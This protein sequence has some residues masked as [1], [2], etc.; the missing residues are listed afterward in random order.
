MVWYH[1][2]IWIFLHH[3]PCFFPPSKRC[4]QNESARPN[5]QYWSERP[6]IWREHSIRLPPIFIFRWH[7]TSFLFHASKACQFWDIFKYVESYFMILLP[8]KHL[9]PKCV[10]N[11]D[12]IFR[13]MNV[14]DRHQVIERCWW[15]GPGSGR[16]VVEMQ[17]CE[18]A[19]PSKCKIWVWWLCSRWCGGQWP[20]SKVT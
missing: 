1:V 2:P 11:F 19:K 8:S 4:R 6:R 17:K 15:E 13:K 12:T 3:F 18:N 20:F 7:T 16:Y 10:S 9:L 5:F 14:V